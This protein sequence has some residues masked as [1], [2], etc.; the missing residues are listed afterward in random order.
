MQPLVSVICVCYNHARFITE[1]MESVWRQ[2]YTNIELVVVDDAS[3][4]DSVMQIQRVLQFHPEVRTLFLPV[5][6]G[7][8]K[9][10]NRALQLCTGRYFIDLAADDV[11]MPERIQRGVEVLEKAG[12]QYGLHFSDAVWMN[13]QGKQLYLQS[14]RFPHQTVP[15]GD[16]YEV[17][18]RRYFICPPSMMFSRELIEKLDGYDETLAY[19]DFD[20]QIRGARYFKF[21]YTPEVLVKKRVVA[22]SMSHT[23]FTRRDKQRYS[24][25]Q[26]CEKIL[27]MNRSKSEQ[28]ALHKR[29][30]YEIWQCF[31]V[32][33]FTLAAKY[34]RLYFRSR[35][36][37]YT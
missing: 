17:L 5:N 6:E 15:Q 12:G 28:Q 2:T 30:T 32:A 26:V 16:V 35:Q 19:E 9:A 4:D 36:I 33:D 31:R 29:I 10:F 20:L 13:E 7:N 18:I 21:C 3:T 24:T 25:F 27:V 8:C 14:D 34:L 22:G 37:S 11:L 23:Q 1:A